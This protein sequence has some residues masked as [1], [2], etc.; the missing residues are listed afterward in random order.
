PEA[1]MAVLHDIERAAGRDRAE[2]WSS[3]TLDLDLVRYDDLICDLPT[4]TLPHPGLRD[5][6]FW[7]REIA[8]L[9][10]HA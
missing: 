4:L 2:R 10:A 9:E 3:R 6:E 5:R 1:V 8:L 7:A